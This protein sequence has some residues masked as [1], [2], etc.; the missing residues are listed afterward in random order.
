MAQTSPIWANI[1]K[2]LIF[3]TRLI[4]KGIPSESLPKYGSTIIKTF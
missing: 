3:I 4:L 1:T 2:A